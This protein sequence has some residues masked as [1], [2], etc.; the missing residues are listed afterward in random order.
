MIY[1]IAIYTIEAGVRK[2]SHY[3]TAEELILLKVD[4]NGK[5]FQMTDMRSTSHPTKMVINWD[6]VS[7]GVYSILDWQD[8]S[9]THEVEWGFMQNNKPYYVNDRLESK[10]EETIY[11]DTKH[12]CFAIGCR[13]LEL[14]GENGETEVCCDVCQ[15]PDDCGKVIGNSTK[16]PN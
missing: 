2:F 5:V 8:V 15:I 7:P 10:D 3:A 16:T 12:Q 6:V 1:R 4:V 9:A 13:W 11:Y 14:R